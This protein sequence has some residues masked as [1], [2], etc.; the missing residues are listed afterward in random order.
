MPILESSHQELELHSWG[1]QW[2]NSTQDGFIEV[3]EL[4]EFLRFLGSREVL[5]FGSLGPIPDISCHSEYEHDAPRGIMIRSHRNFLQWFIWESKSLRECFSRF[6]GFNISK[7]FYPFQH[8]Y[9]V[10]Q[11]EGFRWVLRG[12]FENKNMYE[13]TP[14]KDNWQDRRDLSETISPQNWDREG[15]IARA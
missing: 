1:T 12:F 11:T 6:N 2:L 13:E 7:P 15:Q 14:V 3:T 8:A 4:S 10:A 5:S 9:K